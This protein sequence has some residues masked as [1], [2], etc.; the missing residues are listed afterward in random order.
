[1]KDK[2]LE[3]WLEIV[4]YNRNKSSSEDDI[5]PKQVRIPFTPVI[6]NTKLLYNLFKL[7]YPRFINDQQNIADLII[8]DDEDEITKLLI[9]NTEIPGIHESFEEIEP[10]IIKLSKYPLVEIDAFFRDLQEEIYDEK[11][12]RISHMRI[13]KNEGINLLNGLIEKREEFSFEDFLLESINTLQKLIKNDLFLIYPKPNILSFLEEI[14]DLFGN[15]KLSNLFS[16]LLDLLPDLD[17]SL[18]FYSKEF[19]FLLRIKKKYDKKEE[20]HHLDFEILLPEELEVNIENLNEDEMVESL[21]EKLE[22]QNTY[23]VYQEHILNIL[24]DLFEL[25]VPFK[26]NKIKLLLQKVLFGYRTLDINW[27]RKPKPLIYNPIIRYILQIMDINLNLRNL[28]HWGLSEFIFGTFTSNFGLNSRLILIF[29]NL[30]G[31]DKR[32]VKSIEHPIKE[33]FERGFLLNIENNAL[34]NVQPINK[35]EIIGQLETTSLN[36]LRNRMSMKY[37]FITAVISIDKYLIESLIQTLLKYS[38]FTLFS[39]LSLIRKFGKEYY[40]NIYPKVPIYKFL[41]NTQYFYLVK[42]LLRI[43]IDKYEF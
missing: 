12:S 29:T 39:K 1:M 42:T 32:N 41:K 23:L 40:F 18:I 6:I 13:M 34:R 21:H 16:Y 27:F 38:K 30:H 31:L 43:M 25:K 11:K 19:S 9:Y 7:L 22:T 37:G 4:E 26:L 28:S 2:L 3:N 5:P 20:S 24:E 35:D 10:D 33:G 36:D 14:I 17:F 8:S 15:L